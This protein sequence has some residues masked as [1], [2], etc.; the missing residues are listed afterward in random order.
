MDIINVV[1]AVI[2]V[3]AAV[4]SIPSLFRSWIERNREQANLL[5][6]QHTQEALTRHATTQGWSGPGSAGEV[7]AVKLVS[8]EAEA[9][10][11]VKEVAAGGVTDYIIIQE[12][13]GRARELRQMIDRTGFLSR[14]PSPGEVEILK[15]G[16]RELYV[17]DVQTRF[18]VF[19][20]LRAPKS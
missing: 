5:R 15:Q 18:G 2:I 16:A 8:D 14:P 9:D 10:R 11:V 6:E 3:I 12:T 7:Y 13:Q 20:R 19:G 17:T 4:I 1:A